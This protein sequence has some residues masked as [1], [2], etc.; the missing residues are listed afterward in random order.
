MFLRSTAL[1]FLGDTDPTSSCV[2]EID[3][4]TGEGG[5]GG[6]VS[7]KN[8]RGEGGRGAG[9][10]IKAS[11]CTGRC[12]KTKRKRKRKPKRKSRQGPQEL[13]TAVL[14]PVMAEQATVFVGGVLRGGVD[15]LSGDIP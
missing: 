13:F 6:G 10:Y 4:G 5:G 3:R 15:P 8:R 7:I 12:K 2:T 1:V 14:Y 9:G 11:G